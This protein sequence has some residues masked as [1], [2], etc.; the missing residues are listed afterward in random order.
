MIPNGLHFTMS[1]DEQSSSI[2]V[3]VGAVR[4]QD[5]MLQ[6]APRVYIIPGEETS[7]VGK[8]PR[9]T[10][11]MGCSVVTVSRCPVIEQWLP[12]P[13]VPLFEVWL[14]GL[15]FASP[16]SV[17]SPLKPSSPSSQPPKHM[18]P[19]RHSC[20][21]AVRL[22]RVGKEPTSPTLCLSHSYPLRSRF[23]ERETDF[24]RL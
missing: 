8:M 13:L 24:W 11:S 17:C 9:R 19:A 14:R 22:Y 23:Y 4:L 18:R 21:W 6:L 2:M 5:A 3:I 12:R 20:P 15:A 1:N 16:L 7:T 10:L